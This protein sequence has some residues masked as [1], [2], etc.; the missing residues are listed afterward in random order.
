MFLDP[1]HH[2]KGSGRAM[3]DHITSAKGPLRVEVFAQN[4]IGRPFY[5]NTDSGLK[6][7][8]C[9]IRRAK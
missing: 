4:T 9:T 5:E 6:K 8:I 3:V 2:G 7:S 1:A